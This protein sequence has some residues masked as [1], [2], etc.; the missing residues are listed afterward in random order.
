[1]R[2]GEIVSLHSGAENN[3]NRSP[4]IDVLAGLR[5]LKESIDGFTG[6]FMDFIDDK[7]PFRSR[8]KVILNRELPE[9]C[10]NVSPRHA[11]D[12]SPTDGPEEVQERFAVA[13]DHV[14]WIEKRIKDCL[15]EEKIGSKVPDETRQKIR[16]DARSLFGKSVTNSTSDA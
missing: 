5:G 13:L 9:G 2:F 16:E 6:Q 10:P 15:Y 1:V 3:V 4:Y 7:D 12:F 8:F 14:G 11:F